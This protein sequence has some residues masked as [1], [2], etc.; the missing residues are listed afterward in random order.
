MRKRAGRRRCK[1]DDRWILEVHTYNPST[2]R[3][4]QEDRES[5]ADLG[6]LSRPYLKGTLCLP[7]GKTGP[8]ITSITLQLRKS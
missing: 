2:Q 4:G 1:N 6:C 3:L 7:L 5:K 8:A